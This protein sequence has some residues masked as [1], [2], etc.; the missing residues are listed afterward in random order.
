MFCTCC[1]RLV[2]LARMTVAIIHLPLPSVI[3]GS[4]LSPRACAAVTVEFSCA[5]VPTSP[6]VPSGWALKKKGE[7]SLNIPDVAGLVKPAR[8]AVAFQ[9]G[10]Q[11][12]TKRLGMHALSTIIAV[13]TSVA[14]Q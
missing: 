13:A 1:V 8:P 14:R 7:M 2:V 5:C 10:T 3:D 12:L 9:Y 6:I 11:P 4:T